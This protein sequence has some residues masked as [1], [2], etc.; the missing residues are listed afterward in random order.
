MIKSG[1]YRTRRRHPPAALGVRLRRLLAALFVLGLAVP[2]GGCATA[3]FAIANRGAAPPDATA[4]YDATRGLA[5][6]V[7]APVGAT[8]PAPTVVFFYGGGWLDGA[9][10]QYRFVGRALAERGVLAIVADYRTYPRAA[11]PGFMDDAAQAV[12]WTRTHARRH[13]GD[14]SRLFLAGHSAGAQIAA[15]L[16]TDPRYLREHGLRPDALAGVIGLSGPYDFEITGRYRKVFGPPAQWPRAQAVNFVDGDEPPFLL[17]HG[18]DDRVVEARDST[19]LADRLRANGVAATVVLLPDAGHA[20]TI[21]GLYDARL[22]PEVLPAL[23]AFL[24]R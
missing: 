22:A 7:Y 20:A 8:G 5:L 11:F 18:A 9:R 4:V 23:L 1:R 15:L 10:E 16:A 2:L 14:P 21:A 12:A 6:D 24:R 19:G 3:A 13:G 17:I